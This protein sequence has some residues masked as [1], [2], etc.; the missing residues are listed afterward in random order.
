MNI[1]PIEFSSEEDII[2]LKSTNVDLKIQDLESLAYKML[3][4]NE[5]PQLLPINFNQKNHQVNIEYNKK[6]Y[7]SLSE[8]LEKNTIEYSRFYEISLAII[9]A[10]KSAPNYLLNKEK[11]ILDQSKIYL[12]KLMSDVK[13]LYVPI[14]E[15]DSKENVEISFKRLMFDLLKNVKDISNSNFITLTEFLKDDNFTLDNFRKLLVDVSQGINTI[16]NSYI[17]EN[18]KVDY[19]TVKELPA[20]SRK[21][22]LYSSLIAAILIAIIWSQLPT[23]TDLQLAIA[24]LLTVG[25]LA[26]LY[27]YFKV[28]RPGVEK[29]EVKKKTKPK[30]Q[31]N[32]E[33]SIDLSPLDSKAEQIREKDFDSFYF[34]TEI[35]ASVEPK[36]LNSEVTENETE[37][38]LVETEDSFVLSDKT[39]L[40]DDEEELKRNVKM[41]TLSESY[42]NLYV[43][44]SRI[45]LQNDFE[46]I[47]RERLEQMV[48]KEL[49][50]VS[51]KHLEVKNEENIIFVRD[52]GSS[53][54]TK[55]N[56]E[57]IKPLTFY[58]LSDGD[59]LTLG[60]T[61]VVFKVD[62]M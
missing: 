36:E 32:V 37:Q 54:G 58:K 55:K 60:N 50:T 18:E 3:D 43:G 61:L 27:V 19:K 15:Y 44:E 53:N 10:I 2:K 45:P 52:L 33:P 40:L 4:H 35:E 46:L 9:N 48:S 49:P 25:V 41:N 28:W 57:S 29:I 24:F 42:G 20:P 16:T 39:T 13:I 21:E 14:N 12:G 22:K 8:Y 30:K 59:E 56:G 1:G 11:F 34:N 51:N 5:I 47:G 31:K 62:V 23:G 17:D 7:I 38:S 26:L 6:G